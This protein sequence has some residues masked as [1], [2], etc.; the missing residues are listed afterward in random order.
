MNILNIHGFNGKS[1]NTNYQILKDAG[2]NVI[3]FEFDYE[4]CDPHAIEEFLVLATRI[5]KIDLIVATS[6]GAF[7]A[8]IVSLRTSISFI[9]T[10]PCVEPLVSLRKLASSYCDA[11]SSFFSISTEYL[12]KHYAWLN[13]S[14]IL[15]SKDEIIDY[16]IAQSTFDK[17]VTYKVDGGHQLERD[18]Y[19]DIL[20]KE[21]KEHEMYCMR[22]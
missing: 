19:E 3:S 11:N 20:L 16:S 5:Y 12:Y 8:A 4:N 22:Q 14:Y 9:A 13:G 2:Y 17:A 7:F 1:A 21:I 6:Y 15:G 10:N 18:A